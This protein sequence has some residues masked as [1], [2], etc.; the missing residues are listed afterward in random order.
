MTNDATSPGGAPEGKPEAGPEGTGD[1]ALEEKQTPRSNPRYDQIFP[2]LT[3][4]D[5]EPST[6]SSIPVT[7]PLRGGKADGRCYRPS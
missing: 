1:S 7:K 6:N 2:V 5:I 3:E 4:A